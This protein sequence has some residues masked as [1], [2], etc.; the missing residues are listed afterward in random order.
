ME[1]FD[2]EIHFGISMGFFSSSLLF[3]IFIS[4]ILQHL[5]SLVTAN[6][7]AMW[8]TEKGNHA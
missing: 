3:N 5:T 6:Q 7:E 4:D 1:E 2:D 8:L